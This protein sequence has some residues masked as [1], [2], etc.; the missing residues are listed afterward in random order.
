M[1]DYLES[2]LTLLRNA[3]YALTTQDIKQQVMADQLRGIKVLHKLWPFGSH[4]TTPDK[5][6]TY[7]PLESFSNPMFPGEHNKANF[8]AVD[9]VLQELYAEYDPLV[10]ERLQAV[11]HRLEA[12]ACQQGITIIDDTV[13]SSPSALRAAFDTIKQPFVAIAGGYNN[14]DNYDSLF[15]ESLSHLKGLILYGE[16]RANLYPLAKQYMTQVTMVETLQEALQE[17]WKQSLE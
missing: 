3:R 4:T 7:R 2:K 6:D 1:N 8:G 12:I 9:K 13:S 11:S 17:A 14:G 10:L 16:I 15:D 5:R